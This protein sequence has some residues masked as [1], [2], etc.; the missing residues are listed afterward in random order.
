MKVT[1]VTNNPVGKHSLKLFKVTEPLSN[2][3]SNT[4]LMEFYTMDTDKPVSIL[5]YFFFMDSLE[6]IHYIV[7]KLSKWHGKRFGKSFTILDMK[8]L[9]GKAGLFILEEIEYKGKKYVRIQFP[10]K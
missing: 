6:R 10:E 9:V 5:E 4:I 8:Q 1:L 2:V 3:F 7:N